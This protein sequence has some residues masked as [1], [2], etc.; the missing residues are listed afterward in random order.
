M[1]AKRELRV[2]CIES[3]YLCS[4]ALVLWPEIA[5]QP[6]DPISSLNENNRA[7]HWAQD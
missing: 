1:G 4:G 7:I 3:K 5:F 2:A 6:K